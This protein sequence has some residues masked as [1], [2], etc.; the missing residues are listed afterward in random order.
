MIT[1]SFV[2]HHFQCVYVVSVRFP[3]HSASLFGPLKG[4]KTR[5]GSAEYNLEFNLPISEGCDD[6]S[7]SVTK[8]LITILELSITDV[9]KAMTLAFIPPEGEWVEEERE[10]AR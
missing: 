1:E 2:R 3:T 7:W 5:G 8:V 6:Q 4:S 10:E 9:S